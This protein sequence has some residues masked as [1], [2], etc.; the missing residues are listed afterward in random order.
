MAFHL[1]NLKCALIAAQLH[2]DDCQHFFDERISQ[3]FQFI[4][5]AFDGME[6]AMIQK[7]KFQMSSFL[8]K[9]YERAVTLQNSSINDLLLN[10]QKKVASLCPVE[11]ETVPKCD[12]SNLEKDTSS[13]EQSHFLSDS[14]ISHKTRQNK[15]QQ[16]HTDICNRADVEKI[17]NNPSTSL[18]VCKKIQSQKCTQDQNNSNANQTLNNAI[19]ND[20]DYINSNPSKMKDRSLDSKSM[21]SCK[22]ELCKVVVHLGPSAEMASQVSDFSYK[23]FVLVVS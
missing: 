8:R 18:S 21:P 3:T 9:W 1:K 15:N 14:F 19:A 17:V 5:S 2:E 6:K 23:L 20:S 22:S 10:I 13:R 4:S 16:N 11:D 12:H 7:W